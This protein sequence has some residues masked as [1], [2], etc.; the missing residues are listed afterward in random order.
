MAGHISVIEKEWPNCSQHNCEERAV[1]AYV[2]DREMYGCEK[3]TQA[4]LNI[5]AAMG[6]PTVRNTLKL[7][8]PI[9]F[10]SIP[11]M[12]KEE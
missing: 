9:T 10:A 8:V 2:W 1:Y 11:P 6:F 3:H 7:I 5:A 12:D 4:A